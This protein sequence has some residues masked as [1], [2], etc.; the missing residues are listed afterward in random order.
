VLCSAVCVSLS[1]KRFLVGFPLSAERAHFLSLDR[2]RI[3]DADLMK[4]FLQVVILAALALVGSVAIAMHGGNMASVLL[5]SNW[6]N[7]VA[8]PQVLDSILVF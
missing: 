4:V 8:F 6:E 5:S 3:I 2:V 7:R 1:E